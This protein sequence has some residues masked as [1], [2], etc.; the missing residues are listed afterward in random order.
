MLFES[1]HYWLRNANVPASLIVGGSKWT[2]RK[3]PVDNLLTVDIEI[4][5]GL[6][7]TIMAAGTFTSLSAPSIDLKGGIVWACFVE[8]H[9]HLDKGHTEGRSPNP[10]GSFAG[11]LGAVGR[12]AKKYWSA[13]DVYRRMEFGLKCSYAHGTRAIRTHI[14]SAGKQGP[15]S[16]EV[17]DQLR[18]K[19]A[20][21][22]HLQAVALVSLDHYLTPSGEKLADLVAEK[23]GILGGVAFTNPDLEEQID[24]IGR[25]HV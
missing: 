21:R 11:A 10:D 1:D 13:E 23:G 12:D 14:D 3:P 24:Q 19:W 6:I 22:L 17:F 20:D 9:T 4:Q 25:A 8:L 2:P 16:W 7:S 15:V 5:D 18:T